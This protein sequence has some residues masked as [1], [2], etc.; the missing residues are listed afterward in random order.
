MRIGILVTISNGF[1]KKGYYHSQ[2]VG[3]AKELEKR[4]HM[5][6]IYKCVPYDGLSYLEHA[7]EKVMEGSIAI[8]YIP[9]PHIG[10]HGYISP[11]YINR[12]L[13]ALLAFSDTQIFLPPIIK[14][15]DKNNIIFIP[16]VG[17]AHSSSTGRK[18]QLLD[19][20]YQA[21]TLKEYKKR[22]VIAKTWPVE[23]ELHML[24]VNDTDIAPVGLDKSLLKLDFREFDREEMRSEM[25]YTKDNKVISFVGRM[26]KEKNPD[27]MVRIFKEVHALNPNARLL[28]VGDGYMLGDVRKMVQELN[29]NDCV[30][31]IP[32]VPYEDMWKIHYIADCFVNLCR[33]EIFGMALLEAAF[34]ETQIAAYHA[35]GPDAILTGAKGHYL[36]DTPDEI[37][38]AL[39]SKETYKKEIHEFSEKM[40]S[41]YTWATCA[42][43]IEEIVSERKE[44]AYAD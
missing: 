16:Y 25:G 2:E 38:K 10:I 12:T 17:I 21:G 29:L 28:M 26:Q 20:L 43:I 4:G 11:K 44:S 30:K 37:I 23:D 5:V 8:N 32:K 13:D 24:G 15:C 39:V 27:L 6:T 34:Y 41:I 22:H 33:R 1:G 36:C 18:A 3:L 35:A 40:L 19:A 9:S 14:Y 31:I 7:K 42:D